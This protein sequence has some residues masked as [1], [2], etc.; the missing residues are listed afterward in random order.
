[1]TTLDIIL[2]PMFA[3]KSSELIKRI[4]KLKTLNKN[5][6]VI[7][8]CV[9]NRY[10]SNH[11]V[12][13]D[14][15]R[16]NCVCFDT[17]RNFIEMVDLNN[18]DTIFIDE[19]Q[20]Y[21]DLFEGVIHLIEVRNINIVVVGLD[22]DFNRNKF[23]QILDLIPYSNTCVKLNALCMEC[24]DGTEAAFTIRVTGNIDQVLVGNN[25]YKAVCRNHY[26][27]RPV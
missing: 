4:R 14:N 20:F 27:N 9:D 19:G 26:I 6:M 1:M 12:S 23:G 25:E 13:H 17:I 2:G 7:K 15:I 3:G 8:P 10:S 18:V 22:G 11:V 21:S 5:Y 16:E 24:N